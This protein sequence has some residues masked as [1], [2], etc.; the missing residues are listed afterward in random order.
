MHDWDANGT[1]NINQSTN[2]PFPLVTQAFGARLVLT[3]ATKGMGGAVAKAEAIVA[4]IGENAFM[5]QQFNNP[6][7]PKVRA[8]THDDG[9][10]DGQRFAFALLRS[11]VRSLRLDLRRGTVWLALGF[12]AC[13]DRLRVAVQ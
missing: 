2:N 10:M 5:M 4:E 7:N 12:F 13:T 3:P 11:F 6:D 1:V 9:W 8:R